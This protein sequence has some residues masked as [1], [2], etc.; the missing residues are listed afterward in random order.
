MAK[1][2]ITGLMKPLADKLC[3]RFIFMCMLPFTLVEKVYFRNF[4]SDGLRCIYSF[5][6][7]RSLAGAL[8]DTEYNIVQ[9]RVYS[10][11]EHCNYVQFRTRTPRTT[12]TP[13]TR[14]AKS[15]LRSLWRRRMSKAAVVQTKTQNYMLP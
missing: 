5:P 4:L 10:M 6:S 7:H 12:T 8:L 1:R 11:I 14:T 15:A 3:A 13:R 9:E 2:L